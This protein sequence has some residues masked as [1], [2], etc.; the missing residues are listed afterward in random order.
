MTDRF[1][2]NS[3][4]VD[5]LICDCRIRDPLTCRPRGQQRK[6]TNPVNRSPQNNSVTNIHRLMSG[7]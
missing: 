5:R 2:S 3:T 7:Y 6:G 4:F 1:N